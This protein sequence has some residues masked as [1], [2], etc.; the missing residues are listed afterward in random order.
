[1]Q[2]LSYDEN[3][4]CEYHQ[5]SRHSTTNCMVLDVKLAVKI[6]VGDF[7]DF[8]SIKIYNEMKR[9]SDLT[10]PIKLPHNTKRL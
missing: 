8:I 2:N 9:V 4:F 7:T 3:T 5:S 1:M 6:I 10:R